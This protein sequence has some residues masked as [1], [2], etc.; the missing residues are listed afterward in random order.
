M[1]SAGHITEFVFPQCLGKT[2]ESLGEGQNLWKHERT[3]NQ[4]RG[5]TLSAVSNSS[6]TKMSFCNLKNVVRDSNKVKLRSCERL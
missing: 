3:T 1:V 6:H 5:F 2:N 4:R